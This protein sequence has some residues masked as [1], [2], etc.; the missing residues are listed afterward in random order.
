MLNETRL[1]QAIS[2]LV[3]IVNYR[4]ARLT[5]NCLRS[6]VS[7]IQELPNIRVAVVDNDSGD[8]SIEFIRSA[9]AHES[10]GDW[11]S[12]MPSERNGGYAFGNNLAIRPALASAN[13]PDYVLLL[14]PDTQVYPGA[15]QALVEFMETHAEVGITGSSFENADGTPWPI[16]FR[17]P[18]VLSELDGGLRLGIVTQLLSQWV[19][20]RTMTNQAE[21]VDWLPG[22]S[23]M[24]RRSVFEAIGLMDEGYFLYFEETDF[25][26]QAR[27]A[28]WTCWYVPQSRVMHI[29]GQSTGVTI[30]DRRPNRLPQYWFDSRRR[31]FLKNYG[32]LYTALADLFWAIGFSLWCLRRNLQGK[33]D[34]DPP[35]LLSDFIK[36][37][38]LLKWGTLDF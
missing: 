7:E 28:G 19:V 8:D 9:I 12:L 25:C 5:V 6:L 24:I 18:T 20:P 32:W 38:V 21:Q 17:F 37:S 23:M 30:R 27:R 14:N 29:A 3:V 35:H 33:P 11:V 26:L 15:I 31:Y 34:N 10:W 36:N 16:A 22:A 4:T 1:N 13:P 2:I